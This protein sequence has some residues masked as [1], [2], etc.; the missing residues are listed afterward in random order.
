MCLCVSVGA[1]IALLDMWWRPYPILECRAPNCLS[2]FVLQNEPPRNVWPPLVIRIDDTRVR[3]YWYIPT[4]PAYYICVIIIITTTL[5]IVVVVVV[6]LLLLLLLS[7][8]L[9]LL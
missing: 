1:G 2:S 8:L 3:A 7:L 5:L 4:Q 6:V 9:L